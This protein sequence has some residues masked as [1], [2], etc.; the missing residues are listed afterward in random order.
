MPS[1]NPQ[2]FRPI[3]F[4]AIE[5]RICGKFGHRAFYC[6]FMTKY[7]PEV[8]NAYNNCRNSNVNTVSTVHITDTNNGN[9]STSA[10]N[11][12]ATFPSSLSQ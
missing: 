5:C 10:S 9:N 12:Q 4:V 2:M 3:P 6:E 8:T 11:N 7:F 1:G